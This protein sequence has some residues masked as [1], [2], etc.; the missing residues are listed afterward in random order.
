MNIELLKKLGNIDQ[1]AGIRE[2]KLLRGRG[3]DI[4]LA[5]FYNA[6]GL[7]FSVVPDRCMD[8]WDLSYKGI[9]LSFQ[10]K[11]GLTSPQAYTPADGEFADFKD[12]DYFCVI[13]YGNKILAAFILL[14]NALLRSIH[15][16]VFDICEQ[17]KQVEEE[18]ISL[19]EGRIL[20]NIKIKKE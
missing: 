10:S 15:I 13:P 7:R 3:E 11:N 12:Y 5:E 9:N 8:L 1:L 6:A 18:C 20:E 4:Q 16:Q 14:L 19:Q 2:T 17:I